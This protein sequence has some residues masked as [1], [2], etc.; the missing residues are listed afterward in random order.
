MALG[1]LWA[2]RVA[3]TNTGNLFVRFEGEDNALKGTLHFNEQ[4]VG[5]VVYKL[6]G[7]FDGSRLVLGGTTQTQIPNVAFGSLKATATLQSN[8]NL[9]G[10]WETSIGSAGTFILFPHDLPPTVG[11]PLPDQIHTARH[12]FRPIEIGREQII[13]LADDVQR[14][15]IKG[16]V[17]VTLLAGT[18]QSR[19]LEDFRKLKINVSRAQLVK[20][21]VREPDESGIDRSIT[22]EFGPAVNWAMVQGVSESWALG[23]LERLKREIRSF[24]RFF[25]SQQFGALFTQF[26]L[27]CTL[28]FLPSLASLT[29]RAILMFGVLGLMFS[30]NRLNARYLTHATIYL[31]KRKE[32]WLARFLP[33]AFTWLTGIIGAVIAT[34]LGAY[35]K[36]ALPFPA[37]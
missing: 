22:I 19:F 28:I 36:G 30:I 35:L 6:S 34:L 23:E 12:N 5:L 15:F 21:F 7:S 3:G 27:V 26:M 25:S 4:G 18:E 9:F 1:R 17:V 10:E 33:S 32:G 2:G 8:G 29:Q 24:E 13:A 37:P 14:G 11:V 16:R 20:L 31:G